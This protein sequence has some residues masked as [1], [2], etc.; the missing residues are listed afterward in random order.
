MSRQF[1]ELGQNQQDTQKAINRN[2]T[3]TVNTQKSQRTSLI[4]LHFSGLDLIWQIRLRYIHM[5]L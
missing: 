1:D 3:A 2:E 4:Y 5:P